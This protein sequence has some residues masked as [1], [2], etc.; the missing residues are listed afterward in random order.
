MFT[1]LTDL[2]EKND[3][4]IH[5]IR[6][7]GYD[8]CS[9]MSGKYSGLQARVKEICP[10]AYFV[11]CFCH[12]LNLVVVDS[13]SRN[14]VARNFFGIVE[15]LYAF[16]EGSTKRHGLF[17]DIQGK[18]AAEDDSSKPGTLKSLSTTC[19]LALTMCVYC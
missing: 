17:Q 1:I 4:S 18:M 9:T 19:Q 14:V 16:I 13:C 10:S 7:Q 3:L 5:N 2:L 11:H 15:K 12:R 6:G 8:G